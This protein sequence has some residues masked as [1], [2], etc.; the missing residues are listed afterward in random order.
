M[1]QEDRDMLIETH[2]IVK[3]LKKSVY[4]NGRPGMV[5]RLIAVEVAH[6]ECQKRQSSPKQWPSVVAAVCAVVA[7]AWGFIKGGIR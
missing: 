6:T 4:G 5:D 7:V 1:T 3:D 2:S